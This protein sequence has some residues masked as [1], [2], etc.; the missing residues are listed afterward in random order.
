[1]FCYEVYFRLYLPLALEV[2]YRLF[3][4]SKCFMA[5]DKIKKHLLGFTQSKYSPWPSVDSGFGENWSV[6]FLLYSPLQVFLIIIP[7]CRLSL[8]E[9]TKKTKI[10]MLISCSYYYC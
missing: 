10:D 5:V 7:I 3:I 2:F 8:S 6:Y 1:M 9:R 4:D